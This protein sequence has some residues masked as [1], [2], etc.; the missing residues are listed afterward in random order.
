MIDT[1]IYLILFFVFTNNFGAKS[2]RKAP[3]YVHS[4]KYY[5]KCTD[6]LKHD[7]GLWLLNS[8][9]HQQIYQKCMNDQR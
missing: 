5:L 4:W 3:G 9:G 2:H 7:I 1:C 8:P 6:V